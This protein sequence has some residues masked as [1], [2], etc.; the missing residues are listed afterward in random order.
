MEMADSFAASQW[1]S[2]SSC[3]LIRSFGSDE[4]TTYQWHADI[5]QRPLYFFFSTSSV[6]LYLLRT[7]KRLVRPVS[8][9]STTHTRCSAPGIKFCKRHGIEMQI[10][11][12]CWT[13]RRGRAEEIGKQQLQCFLGGLHAVSD[14]LDQMQLCWGKSTYLRLLVGLV[15]GSIGQTGSQFAEGWIQGSCFWSRAFLFGNQ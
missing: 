9:P 2:V 14:W 12:C 1:M 13:R 6:V 11:S 7:I 10:S 8:S 15:R 5:N 3:V 4:W